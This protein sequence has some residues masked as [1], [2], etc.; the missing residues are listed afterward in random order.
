M[1]MVRFVFEGRGARQVSVAGSFND[2]KPDALALESSDHDGMFVATIALPRGVH[3]YMFVVD[4]KW[5]ADPM[6]SARRPDGFGRQNSVLR[7]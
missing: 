1:V 6:T 3:E 7:L 4:G 5:V 2:W